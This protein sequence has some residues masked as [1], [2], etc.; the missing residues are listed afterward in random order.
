MGKILLTGVTGLVGSSF[1]VALLREKP[2]ERFVCISRA[3]NGGDAAAR[4]RQILRDQCKFDGCLEAA[5]RIL[6]GVE[7]VPG[8]VVDLIPEEMAKLPALKDVDRVFHCA[9]DVNLGKDPTGKTFR[10]NYGGTVNMIELAKLLKVREFHYVSTAYVA[11]RLSGRAMEEQAL[12]KGFNNPYEESKFRAE[13]LVRS[14]GMPFTIYR[15]AIITGRLTDGRVRRPLAFYRVVEFLAKLK[16]N[17]CSKEGLNPADWVDMNLHFRTIASEHVYFVPID[18]VQKAITA[19]F[20]TPVVNRTFHVTGNSPVETHQ[21]ERAICNILKMGSV[22]VSERCPADDDVIDDRLMS[23]FLGDL[24]PYFASNIIFDQSNVV[25]ALGS[26]FINWDFGE[27]GI[28]KI[29][30][31]FIDDFLPGFE[32]AKSRNKGEKHAR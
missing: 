15:P 1:V 18:Y 11:G 31:S 12:N 28:E 6:S 22:E 25:N 24:L 8:D 14:S 20:Q 16:Q 3:G 13:L 9:A 10:I 7:I 19:L 17:R 27:K 21:I 2:T 23:R 32:W 26:E 30:R 29:V 4:V 5:D